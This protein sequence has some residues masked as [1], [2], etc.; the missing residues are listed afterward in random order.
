LARA[1]ARARGAGT[2]AVVGDARR[3]TLWCT[4]YDVADNGAV[5]L[6]G[7]GGVPAHA[8]SDFAIPAPDALAGTIPEGALVVSPEYTHLATTLQALSG[9]QVLAEEVRP[10][11]DDLAGLY[12][13]NPDAAVRDPLP[14]YLHPAVVVR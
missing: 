4:V 7:T 11:A 12:F 3:G 5:T 8:A 14:I 1:V 6:H 10:S 13:A 2:V 9:A